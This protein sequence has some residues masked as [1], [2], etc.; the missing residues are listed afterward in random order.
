[1]C[2]SPKAPPRCSE[3]TVLLSLG[4]LYKVL[5]EWAS[6]ETAPAAELWLWIQFKRCKNLTLIPS[7]W[8]PSHWLWLQLHQQDVKHIQI[9]PLLLAPHAAFKTETALQ[10]IPFCFCTRGNHWPYSWRLVN[11]SA[12]HNGAIKMSTPSHLFLAAPGPIS[13]TFWSNHLCLTCLEMT[14]FAL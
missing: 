13:V 8:M 1:M 3:F 11:V 2:H 12:I 4:K 9:T 10:L 14:H 5:A 7:C 6:R